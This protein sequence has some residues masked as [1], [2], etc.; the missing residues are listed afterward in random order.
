MIDQEKR[1]IQLDKN[2]LSIE[3]ANEKFNDIL[4]SLNTESLQNQK[5]TDNIITIENYVERYIP[6]QILKTIGR[7]VRPILEEPMRKDLDIET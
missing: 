3:D 4:T 2:K 1:M 5:N 6:M 7:V